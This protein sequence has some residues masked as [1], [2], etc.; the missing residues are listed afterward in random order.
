MLS[1]E[2]SVPLSTKLAAGTPYS[3]VA[4][5]QDLREPAAEMMEKL[6][7]IPETVHPEVEALVTNVVGKTDSAPTAAARITAYFRATCEYELG[8]QVPDGVDPIEYFLLEKPAAHCEYFATATVL[9]LRLAGFPARYVTGFV[10][11]ERNPVGEYWVARSRD[12]HAWAEV[13]DPA[14]G[15]ITVES[16]PA[17]G[18]PSGGTANGLSY[19]LDY[20]GQQWNETLA[21][22]AT[23]GLAGGLRAAVRLMTHTMGGLGMAT[24]ALGAAV[25]LYR[26]GRRLTWPG[27][28]KPSVGWQQSL[29]PEIEHLHTLRL[30]QD[31][32]LQALGLVREIDETLL[33]FADRIRAMDGLVEREALASW[34]ER[35]VALRFQ[36]TF[37]PEALDALQPVETK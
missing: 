26:Y 23:Q 24:L 21:A 3:V 34:Y 2:H 36:G 6:R 35:Y 13:F 15:W 29:A 25:L 5:G 33:E 14:R 11:Q 30:R 37:S 7:A 12:A 18:V 9:M 20:L 22:F 1:D 27:R 16:T 28:K 4:H 32:T 8:I 17:S 31:K 19:W 10:V